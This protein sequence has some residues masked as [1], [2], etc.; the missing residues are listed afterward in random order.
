MKKNLQSRILGSIILF[1]LP[2]MYGSQLFAQ[3]IAI[4]T[5]GNVPNASAILD[6]DA[7][8][9]NNL[10]ILIPRIPLTATNSNLPIGASITTSLLVYNTATA[11]AAP[12]N[13]LPGFYYWNGTKW[14]ALSGGT[15]GNDWG[16]LGNS[17]T[18]DGTNFIG[19]TDTSALNFKVN[20]A[21]A[22]RID[23]LGPTF[24]GYL[25]GNVN[26]D[27][28]NTGI[29]AEALRFNT[30]GANNTAVGNV[31]LRSNTLGSDNTAVG[32]GALRNNTT[33]SFNS[34]L[35]R[36]AL[37]NNTTGYENTSLGASA[38]QQNTTGYKNTAI[39]RTALQQ[40]TTGFE[41]T[42]TGAYTLFTNQTGNENTANGTGALFN[43]T[44]GSYNSG[45]GRS[46]LFYSGTGSYNVGM[47]YSAG[48]GDTLFTFNQCTFVGAQSTA[49][50]NRT[51]VTM[52]GYGITNG[53]VTGNNQVLLGNTAITQIRAQVTG[54]T[55]YSDERFK[56][57]ISDNVEGLNFILKLKP[58]IYNVLPN[59]LHKIWGTSTALT[60][61]IDHNDAEKKRY[62]GFVAQ[63]VEKAANESG[64]NFPGI[65]IPNNDKEVYSL[66]Y[67]DFIM[68][69]VKAIQELKVENDNLKSANMNLKAEINQIKE[70][71]NLK[72]NN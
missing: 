45:F 66:R 55:A 59:E 68:P 67:V 37:F 28:K 56:T 35:G 44:T 15:G 47:G 54:I 17:G 29:G 11:G 58:V 10:G 51:N 24:L 63:D 9:G 6:I 27:I 2:F 42:A 7:S 30:T 70:A 48:Q 32:N 40:T 8:P 36:T 12:N 60:D 18:I 46:A 16:L 62:I 31:A 1:F 39:G 21:K 64:F 34:V 49:T 41:N 20:N 26:T 33:G 5:T 50:G 69:I 53:Q 61:K 13:V 14:I 72:V 23:R 57:N 19:T 22:G 3:N 25:A 38:M 71:I 65:D 52:L 4:N 43:N